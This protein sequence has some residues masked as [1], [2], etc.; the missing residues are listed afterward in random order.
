MRQLIWLNVFTVPQV[1]YVFNILYSQIQYKKIKIQKSNI[2]HVDQI[3]AQLTQQVKPSQIIALI[4]IFYFASLYR[5]RPYRNQQF[6][7][8]LLCICRSLR[9]SNRPASTSTQR[10]KC[11]SLWVTREAP[12]SA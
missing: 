2:F 9:P 10:S 5:Y 3:W 8:P 1:Y 4:K 6:D 12:N 7:P 11:A